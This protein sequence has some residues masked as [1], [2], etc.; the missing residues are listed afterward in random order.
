MSF[1]FASHSKLSCRGQEYDIKYDDLTEIIQNVE[2]VR[3]SRCISLFSIYDLSRIQHLISSEQRKKRGISY[4]NSSIE[5]S[6]FMQVFV[7]V[8][9]RSFTE[10]FSECGVKEKNFYVDLTTINP[11]FNGCQNKTLGNTLLK[12][13]SQADE[14]R[15]CSFCGLDLSFMLMTFCDI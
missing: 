4:K 6:I 3:S 15:I 12:F 13:I 1:S 14:A 9:V 8:C 5:Q 11:I 7:R 2:L 10:F